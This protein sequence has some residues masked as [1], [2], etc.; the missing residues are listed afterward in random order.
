MMIG[1]STMT[2]E[3]NYKKASKIIY[4]TMIWSLPGI[5]LQKEYDKSSEMFWNFSGTFIVLSFLAGFLWTSLLAYKI[6]Q[7]KRWAILTYTIPAILGFIFTIANPT[8]SFEMNIIYGLYT[9]ISIGIQG[10]IIYLLRESL[11]QTALSFK[12]KQEKSIQQVDVADTKLVKSPDELIPKQQSSTT[13]DLNDL[14]KLHELCKAGAIT[15]EEFDQQKKKIL[16]K[17]A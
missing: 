9:Y 5:Y 13:Y 3:N 15:Q 11:I 10:C 12:N 17:A 6:S 14:G 7:G 16:R 8:K 2:N 4:L 1:E